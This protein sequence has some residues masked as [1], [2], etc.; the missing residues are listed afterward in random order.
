MFRKEDNKITY[1]S[2]EE[3]IKINDISEETVANVA[4]VS[5]KAN[6]QTSIQ[7]VRKKSKF[8]IRPLDF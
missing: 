7:P 4:S 3:L 1:A 8:C 6:L 5:A 2:S